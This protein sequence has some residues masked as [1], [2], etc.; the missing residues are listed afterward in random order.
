MSSNQIRTRNMNV[1]VNKWN[2]A[3]VVAAR[4][5]DIEVAVGNP[6]NTTVRVH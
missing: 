6:R 5:T 4:N 1:G 2:R 3:A